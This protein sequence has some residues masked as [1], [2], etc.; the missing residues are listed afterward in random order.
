MR[1]KG[2]LITP[3]MLKRLLTFVVVGGITL[4][5]LFGGAPKA[6]ALTLSPPTFE[7]TV[8]P[9][10]TEFGVIKL[11][12]EDVFT[13]TFYPL[14]RNFTFTD[15]S[16]TPQFYPA[17]EERDG[18][19][20]GKWLTISSLEPITLEPQARANISYSINVP[21]DAQPGGH[22]GGVLFSTQPPDENQSGVGVGAQVGALFLVRVS[23][24]AKEA[25]SIAE[26]GFANPRPWHNTLPIDLFL[27]FENSGNVHLRPTGNVFVKNMLG[28]QVASIRVNESFGGVLP[29][30]IR[31]FTFG[32]KKAGID[33]TAPA[34]INEWKNFG[35][36]RYTATLVLNYGSTNK[37]I[38]QD[39][40]FYV[41]PWRLMLVFGIG[42]ILL[43]TILW[44][45][46][47][48]YDR[49][50]IAKFQKMQQRSYPP[51]M[52]R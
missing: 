18:T 37:I 20:L 7:A 8:N 47:R 43:L 29:H 52:R 27:R 1:Q 45:M 50:I 14:V 31:R 16:G 44:L 49:G 10:D 36:G 30:S 51:G 42:G 11:Y 21:R 35:F 34:I 38:S 12:N 2:L 9:G 3:C 25:A 22:Y 4:S 40:V 39:L 28:Q 24:E 6:D 32:W 48:R 26:Y 13:V 5:A 17:T 19:G 46:K 23:G 41:W 15:E 33:P